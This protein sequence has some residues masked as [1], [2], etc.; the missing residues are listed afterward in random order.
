MDPKEIVAQGYDQI[1]A[2]YA[3][4]AP[5]V[6]VEERAHYTTVLLESLPQNAKILELGCGS[7]LPTTKRL[8]ERFRV[9][10]VDISGQQIALARQYLPAVNFV[11]AD[12]TTLN[13]PS[14]SFDGVAAFYAITHVPRE[15]H[16]QLLRSIAQWL[17]PGG[18][19][20]ASMGAKHS[21]GDVEEE[22]LGAPMY[23][24]HFDAET[25]RKSVEEA[26]LQVVTAYVEV[27]EEDGESVAFLWI[28]AR[29]PIRP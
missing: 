14:S 3:D 25:N 17:R 29:K 24:S 8:A 19:F 10:G 1:A 11:H 4:W 22:W 15:E 18:L 13:L 9:T 16:E 27:A 28:V 5:S 6:R 26:G 12:M 23:F 2:R 21:V 20:V 7:G